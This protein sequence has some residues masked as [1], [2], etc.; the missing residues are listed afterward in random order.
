LRSLPTVP[1]RLRQLGLEWDARDFVE[2]DYDN[3]SQNGRAS[4]PCGKPCGASRPVAAELKKSGRL[5]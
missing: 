3:D 2:I 5:K 4:C 1:V